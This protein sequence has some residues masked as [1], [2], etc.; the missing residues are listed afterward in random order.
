MGDK[1]KIIIIIISII[2]LIFLATLSNL[3]KKELETNKKSNDWISEN[4]QLIK[5]KSLGKNIYKVYKNRDISIYNLKYQDVISKKIENLRKDMTDNFLVIYN[6]YGT[7]SLSI[8]VLFKDTS[9]YQ[10]IKYEISTPNSEKFTGSLCFS[11]DISIYQLIGLYPGENNAVK[12]II[13][14]D[15]KS[16]S[17]D[18]SIDLSDIEISAEKKLQVESGDSREEI[19]EGLFTMLGNESDYQNYIAFYD[20]NGYVRGELPLKEGIANNFLLA[21]SSMFYNVSKTEIIRVNNLGKITNIYKTG[22]YQI[23]SDFTLYDNELLLLVTD[24]T[25]NTVKDKLVAI[26]LETN[27]VVELLDLSKLFKDYLSLCN[28]KEDEKLN[29]LDINY[30]TISDNNLF[31]SSKETSSIIKIANFTDSAKIDYIISSSIFWEDTPYSDLV[32]QKLGDFKIHAGQSNIT[33]EKSDDATYYIRLFN[34]NYGNSSTRNINYLDI[35]IKNNNAYQ[36]DK[37]FYYV[38][39]IDEA[40]KTFELV[41]SFAF[42]YSGLAGNFEKI[43]K[44]ILINSSTKGVFFE[45][46][47]DY[48]LIKKYQAK[49]NKNYIYK[50]KK[51]TFKDFLFK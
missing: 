26:N 5:D 11:N 37:S 13:S 39:K 45:F 22:K 43:N 16:I 21:N 12:L 25:K 38:Y 50:I 28:S 35:D 17:Y 31:L 40:N 2:I 19:S 23:D 47:A 20:N 48:Q 1:K 6:P 24:T 49:M 14:E 42:D 29:Y 8:N 15:N 7:N 9:R 3:N 44:N 4:V 36:G 10:D 32:Y 30:F 41:N 46:D 18:F 34:N 27:E 51:Y 33:I